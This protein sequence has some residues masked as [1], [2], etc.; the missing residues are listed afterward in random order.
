MGRLARLPLADDACVTLVH[1]VPIS[2]VEGAVFVAAYFV[3]LA[4]LVFLRA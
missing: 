2:R 1:V 4:T 3:Y